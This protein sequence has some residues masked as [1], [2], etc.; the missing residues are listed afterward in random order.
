MNQADNRD[1]EPENYPEETLEPGDTPQG[2]KTENNCSADDRGCFASPA[3]VITLEQEEGLGEGLLVEKNGHIQLGEEVKEK[4][5]QAFKEDREERDE[6]ESPEA[7]SPRIFGSDTDQNTA[8]KAEAAAVKILEEEIKSKTEVS[9]P[10]EEGPIDANRI[11]EII[12]DRIRREKPTISS[13]EIVMIS[14]NNFALGLEYSP[15]MIPRIVSKGTGKKSRRMIDRAFREDIPVVE[16]EGWTQKDS[17]KIKLDQEIPED[18]YPEAARALALVYR[19][20]PEARFVRFL[21]PEKKKSSRGKKA[22]HRMKEFEDLLEVIPLSVEVS[23]QLFEYR[24]EMEEAFHLVARQ[25]ASY[26]GLVIPEIKAVHCAGLKGGQCLLKIR[27]ISYDFA[28]LDLAMTPPEIFFPL[29]NRL[30]H[31]LSNY[32]FELLGYAETE[33]IIKKARKDHPGLIKSLFPRNFTVGGLRFVLRGLLR[34]RIPI[35]DIGAIL[36]TIDGHIH[37]TDD[38]ELLIEYIRARF[39]QYISTVYRD[40]ENSLNVLLLSP[41]TDR[42]ILR[43]IKEMNNVRWLDMDYSLGFRFLSRLA[44]ELKAVESLGM[45]PVILTS[46]VIRRFV[47]KITEASFPHIPVISYSEIAPMTPIKALG[48]IQL[49][50]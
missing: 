21:K 38:P 48:T 28:T 11:P 9:S 4:I 35:K 22:E 34:E 44:D 42:L 43:S 33:A 26:L 17:D 16:V 37:L 50:E 15:G 39:S 40:E 2:E 25:M 1:M 27:G 31:L 29:Q 47:R 3:E 41:E 24:E 5:I 45:I 32:G 14:Q 30:R 7:H 10:P 18:L 13:A 23:G 19:I 8:R 36:G 20:K 6:S 49:E 12:K 46:P